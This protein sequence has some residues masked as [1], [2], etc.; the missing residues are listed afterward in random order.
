MGGVELT[1]R[2][3]SSILKVS[4]VQGLVFRAYGRG[5]RVDKPAGLI[6]LDSVGALEIGLATA[7]VLWTLFVVQTNPLLPRLS[8]PYPA[9]GRVFFLAVWRL[10]PGVCNLSILQRFGVEWL[11]FSTRLW[12]RG[13][14]TLAQD[15]LKEDQYL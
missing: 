2:P 6:N 1:N 10:W 8:L 14:V 11:M 12:V 4:S 5:F 3:I 15:A 9:R 7:S 13:L